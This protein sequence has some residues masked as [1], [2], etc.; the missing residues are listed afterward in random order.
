MENEL[1]LSKDLIYSIPTEKCNKKDIVE[2]LNKHKEIKFVSFVGIDL[3]GN[4]TDEKIPVKYFIDN[5]DD[6]LEN[7]M[8]TDGSSVNLGQ[9]ATL[10][11]A[12][13][14]L[15]PDK[16]SVWYVDYNYENID[17]ETKLPT[18]T[19]RIWSFLKHNG[20]Y[21]DSRAL[22]K[23]SVNKVK[24]YLLN[25]ID[26]KRILNSYKINSIKDVETVEVM[27]GTELEFW[28]RTPYNKIHVEQLAL[29]QK[30][31]EQYWKR[32]KGVVRTALEQTLQILDLY[33]I[34][35]EMGHKEV[36]G[37]KTY[38]SGGGMPDN[39]IVEQLEIDWKYNTATRTADSEILA[40]I[41]IKEVFRLYGLE[42]S[43]NAKPIIGV[44]GSGKHCHF[45]FM[46]KLKNGKLINLLASTEEETYLSKIGWGMLMG[47][48]KN[49]HLINPF[50]ANTNDSLN[51]LKPGFEAPTHVVASIGKDFNGETRNRTVLIGLVKDKYNPLSTRLEVRSPNPKTNTFL[52][53]SSILASM[54]DGIDYCLQDGITNSKLEQEVCKDYSSEAKYLCKNRVYR[55]EEDIFE[56]YSSEERDKLFGKPPKTVY[57]NMSN[58]EDT[59]VLEKLLDKNIIDAHVEI[60]IENWILD[61]I[62]RIIPENRDTIVSYK[63]L[64]NLN[65]YDKSLWNKILKLKT[66][67]AKDDEKQK[68]IF[69]R[70]DLLSKHKNFKQVSELQIE[71]NK[72][73]ELLN[74]LYIQY[75]NNCI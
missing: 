65:K 4:D 45:S 57:E 62:Q 44:A 18:G 72:K 66:E 20:Q 29:S 11:D 16:E 26:N 54:V 24:D 48:L 37:V 36:G 28:I 46:L 3:L 74:E 59:K 31:K 64:N 56:T 2:L 52:A 60:S 34:K 51:R 41:I 32:T 70:I 15:I 40:R 61:L 14:D 35:P 71:M 73:M 25:K 22:L 43:F 17:S 38:I 42:V 67:L 49:Y 10:S 75:K 5:I 9:I 39:H 19:L 12:R 69:S 1:I 50:V 7:G 6:M 63:K 30:M 55:E 68:S 27:I 53:V 47:T 13:V 33:G 21:V 8:Q 58:L 23:E